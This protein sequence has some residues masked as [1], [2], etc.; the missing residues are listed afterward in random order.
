MIRAVGVHESRGGRQ[1]S[2]DFRSFLGPPDQRSLTLRQ[3]MAN[4]NSAQVFDS[5][6]GTSLM[7]KTRVW[8]L[9]S[10]CSARTHTFCLSR[11]RHCGGRP[12]ANGEHPRFV[13]NWPR[14]RGATYQTRPPDQGESP[15]IR[16]SARAGH[17]SMALSNASPRSPA[18]SAVAID[19]VEGHKIF[20]RQRKVNDGPSFACSGRC[21]PS[22]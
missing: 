11:A 21:L 4:G 13:R 10:L 9:Q 7:R 2:P 14:E 18:V 1:G 17:S 19:A 5:L 8:R 22:E 16:G 6:T 12:R 3:V 15:H 20:L